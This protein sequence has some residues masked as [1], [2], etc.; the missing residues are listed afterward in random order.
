MQSEINRLELSRESHRPAR[1][2]D[3]GKRLKTARKGCNLR[4]QDVVAKTKRIAKTLGPEFAIPMSRL[5]DF[6]DGRAIPTIYKL[7]SL[8]AVYRLEMPQVLKWYGVQ[9]RPL[10]RS[11][12]AA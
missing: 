12:A 10:L 1:L 7:S 3:A 4:Y 6:E 2:A 8:C 9:N 11:A 5:A